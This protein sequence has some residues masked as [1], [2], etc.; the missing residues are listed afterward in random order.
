ME[1]SAEQLAELR[2]AGHRHPTAGVRVKALAVLAVARGASFSAAAEMFD[3]TYH[4][5]STWVHG[6]LERGLTAF[7]VAPGRGRPPQVDEQQLRQCALQSP[8]R[9]GHNCSRWSLSLLART[10]PSLHGFTPAG[11]RLAL[12]RC[13]LS[14]KRGQAWLSSPDPDFEKK[15]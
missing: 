4:S 3:A 11:V 13:G 7:E 5:V 8:R 12:R 6:Y 9:F 2:Q 15:S 10:V 14:Y 1:F